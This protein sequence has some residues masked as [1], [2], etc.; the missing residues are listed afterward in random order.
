MAGVPPGPDASDDVDGMTAPDAPDAAEDAGACTPVVRTHPT[1]VA[2]APIGSTAPDQPR[3]I[4]SSI[5]NMAVSAC[6]LRFDLD[7]DEQAAFKEGRVRGLTLTL[8]RADQHQECGNDCS[9]TSYR[10]PGTLGVQAL[11]S[12]WVEGA[13]TWNTRDG[14]TPWAM[15]GALGAGDVGAVAGS[16]VL[17]AST[18]IASVDLDPKAWSAGLLT[19]GSIAFRTTFLDGTTPTAFVAVLRETTLGAVVP[20]TPPTLVV[21]YC[22]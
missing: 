18:V 12:D 2:D 14:T 21:R 3:G 15:P 9:A 16:L 1:S 17:P 5:C 13:V 10:K 7:A 22:P 19:G 11:S 20:A 4:D 6:V 8:R